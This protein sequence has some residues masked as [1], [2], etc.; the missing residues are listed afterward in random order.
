MTILD[1]I[2]ILSVFFFVL[3]GLWWG[4][5]H[6]LGGVVGTIFGV[7][8]AGHYAAR[9][10]LFGESGLGR[11]ITFLLLMIVVN[12]LIGLVF[13]VIE[14]LFKIVAI[15]PGLKTVEKLAGGAL[16]FIEGVIVVGGALYQAARY[17]VGEA[18]SNALAASNLG[19]WLVGA[20]GLFA[21]LMPEIIRNLKSVI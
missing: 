15:I 16:G 3:L 14:K 9:G 12:R 13:W 19:Q 8:V 10:A 6:A 17:P 1:L 7:L 2:L 4:F 5:I 21:P 20:F 11:I 18:F